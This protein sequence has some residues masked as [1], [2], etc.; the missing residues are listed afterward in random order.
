MKEIRNNLFGNQIISI[1]TYLFSSITGNVTILENVSLNVYGKINGNLVLCKNSKLYL[2]GVIIG[3]ISN[4]GG[5]LTIKG[6]LIGQI[7]EDYKNNSNKSKE[8]FLNIYFS[9]FNSIITPDTN[10]NLFQNIKLFTIEI[11]HEKLNKKCL[12]QGTD[13]LEVKK[14]ANIQMGA[15]KRS[16]KAKEK[17]LSINHF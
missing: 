1:D 7:N 11:E 15:W 6:S 4:Q 5:T 17:K 12:I 8:S 16:W 13:E 14:Q 3:N 2:Y 10:S 9:D